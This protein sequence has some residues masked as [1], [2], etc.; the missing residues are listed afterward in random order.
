MKPAL[1]AKSRLII[2]GIETSCDETA[3]AVVARDADGRG[4]ILSNVIRSQIAEHAD[5]GGVVPEIAARAHL[6]VLDTLI[7]AALSEAAVSLDDI[8]GIAATAGPG[9]IGGLLVGLTMG[10]AIAAARNLPFVAVNHLEG[11]ALTVGLTEGL[12]PP[13]LLLLVS[14]GHTQLIAVHEIERYEQLGTTLDDAAGEVFDKTAKLLGLEFPGGPAVERWAANGDPK[15]FAFPRPMMGRPEPDFSFSGLKTSLRHAAAPLAP[16]TDRDI[17]DLCAS[18]QIAVAEA[19]SDRV[20]AAI[21]RFAAT[22]PKGAQGRL[23]AA[24]GVAANTAIRGALAQAA[25]ANGFSVHFPPIALCTDNAAMIAWAGAERLS[26]GWISQMNAPARPR[27]PLRELTTDT[28]T[29]TTNQ[30]D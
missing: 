10:K 24:G 13:Y 7:L 18:F 21:K 20:S 6:E 16:L 29:T 8:D 22:L 4:E 2:L 25:A 28:F 26:R 27:W 1:A 9:L 15:R 14:G 17:A 19:I 30:D 11:H 3:A 5:Y 23:V 12:Q